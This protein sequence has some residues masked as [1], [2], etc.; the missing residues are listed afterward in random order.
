MTPIEGALTQGVVFSYFSTL[1]LDKIRHSNWQIAQWLKPET[2][3]WIVKGIRGA[4]S[5]ANSAGILYVW[6]P[7][8]G[9]LT[10]SGL[11]LP[12]L[13]EFGRIAIFNYIVMAI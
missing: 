4:V 10:I 11:T 3:N 9:V 13:L 12:H 1:I 7:S 5:F 6:D 2:A 8:E